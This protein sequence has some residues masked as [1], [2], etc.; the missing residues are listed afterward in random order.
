MR[1]VVVNTLWFFL[2]ITLAPLVAGAELAGNGDGALANAHRLFRQ[3]DFR[4]AAAAFR[5]II[6]AK[7]SPRGVRRSGPQPFESG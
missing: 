1:S 2:L 4:G 3:A 7:P 5:K 6:D